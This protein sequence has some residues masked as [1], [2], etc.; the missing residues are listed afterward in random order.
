MHVSRNIHY[1]NLAT[2]L[3]IDGRPRYLISALA[4]LP[5][6]TLSSIVAGRHEPSERIRRELAIVLGV[7]EKKLW[8]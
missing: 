1:K 5:A 3:A 7:D 8:S 2:A 4:G 6:T